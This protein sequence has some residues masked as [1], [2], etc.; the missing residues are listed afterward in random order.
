M[1]KAI[2]TG[3]NGTIGPYVKKELD[4]S[5]LM[6]FK[7]DRNAV[8]TTD[9]EE[10]A[11]FLE[12]LEP[13]YIFHLAL[14]T[15]EWTS[16]L[17]RYCLKNKIKFIFTSSE[18][19]FAGNG[20]FH[21]TDIPNATSDYGSYKIQCE[22]HIRNINP[23]AFIIRLGW[24]IGDAF[25]KNNM[26]NYLETTYQ[27]FGFIEA[28][29]NWIISTSYLKETAKWIVKIALEMKPDIY[30]IEGNDNLSF[31]ELVKL[32]ENKYQ[33]EWN[34]RKVNTPNRD[35]RLIDDRIKISNLNEILVIETN[36]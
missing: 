13:D 26:L 24:Q 12:V 30:H 36:N 21:V 31:Y 28:S 15:I 5:G 1:K 2:I 9:E 16:F 34:V 14:G 27:K 8:S 29:E 25:E 19:V 33:K 22:T 17:A 11:Q 3:L 18:S 10:M 6:V 7:W 32:I 4:R 23:E 35:N 20:P